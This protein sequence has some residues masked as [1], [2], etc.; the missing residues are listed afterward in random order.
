MKNY[1]LTIQYDGTQYAGWQIQKNSDTIQQRITD[2]LEI[3]TK[4]KINLIGSGRTDSGVHA[5]GQIANFRTENELNIYRFKHSLNSMLPFDIAVS[6][7]EEV[8]ESFHSRFD[9]KRRTYFYLLTSNK[10]PFYFNYSYFY[11]KKIDIVK[12][13]L[14][15]KYFIGENDF[16][17]FSR[18]TPL[19]ENKNCTVYNAH[20]RKTGDNTFFYIQANRYLH[21]M[22]RA[23]TGTMLKAQQFDSSE[24]FI[25]DI[26]NSKNREESYDSV[27]A[28]GLY[29]YKVEY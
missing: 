23:I 14:I 8:D 19:L 24:S 28:K 11:H 13:N 21:G 15:S 6:E 5:F 4:E 2:V 3:L 1:K 20:W 10:S 29:L 18:K 25:K 7:M 9:A 12:L 17:S 16:S 27:P 26:F 22:V